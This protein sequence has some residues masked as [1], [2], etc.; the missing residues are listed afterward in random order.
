MIYRVLKTSEIYSEDLNYKTIAII[1][2][3]ANITL[4]I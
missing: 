2:L 1:R 4:D 3:S